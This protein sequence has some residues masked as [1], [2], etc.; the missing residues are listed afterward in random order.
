MTETMTMMNA[1][2]MVAPILKSGLHESDEDLK[3]LI[4]KMQRL[5]PDGGYLY[6][7]P[8]KSPDCEILDDNLAEAFWAIIHK[9]EEITGE[10]VQQHKY[11]LSSQRA[12]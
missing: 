10:N 8:F 6:K 3:G 12:N 1:S 2:N 5:I 4:S 9:Y 11:R 7:N